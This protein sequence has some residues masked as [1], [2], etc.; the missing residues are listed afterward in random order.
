MPSSPAKAPTPCVSRPPDEQLHA[1]CFQPDQNRKV[2]CLLLDYK[3]TP[4]TMSVAKAADITMPAWLATV[5]DGVTY[6]VHEARGYQMV[7]TRHQDTWI[8]LV[9]KLPPDDLIALASKLEF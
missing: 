8:C 3:N 6:Y 7:M 2:A 5:R 9:A 4:L 1:C